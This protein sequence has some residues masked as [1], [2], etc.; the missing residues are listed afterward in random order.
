MNTDK[1]TMDVFREVSV[2]LSRLSNGTPVANLSHE[3]HRLDSMVA[4]YLGS[5]ESSVT[6]KNANEVTDS[7]F[8]GRNIKDPSEISGTKLV[9]GT[10]KPGS[11]YVAP[12]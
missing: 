4:G 6:L 10:L 1:E 2:L 12:K 11:L 5:K 3:I 7:P 9:G 8:P